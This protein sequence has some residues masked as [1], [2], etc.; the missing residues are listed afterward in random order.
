MKRIPCFI[1]ARKNSKSVKN[2]NIVKLNGIPLIVYT[3]KY[4]KKS[5]LVSD[6]IISTDDPKVAKISE[7]YNCFTIY[8]RPKNLSND[9]ASAEAALKHALKI[10]ESKSK[11]VDVLAYVQ[12]TEPFRPRNILDQCIAKLLKNKKIDSCFAAYAQHKNFWVKKSNKLV[13]ISNYKDR[14]KR[15]Q[16]K[17]TILREDTGIALATRA[18]FI[19]LGERIGKNI[20]C[21]EYKDPKFN[22]DI[23]TLDDLKFAKR[24]I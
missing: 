12:I 3:I 4:V 16:I 11:I 17:N 10:Y 20:R 23:N 13:R 1:L 2:K 15:R 19:K 9:R 21:I 7:K 14:Y 6:I 24:Q 5:K 22:I 8:P 18:K